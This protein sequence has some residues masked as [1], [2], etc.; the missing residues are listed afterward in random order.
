MKLKTLLFSLFLIGLATSASAQYYFQYDYNFNR[1]IIEHVN[2]NADQIKSGNISSLTVTEKEYRKNGH[3]NNA[4]VY[5]KYFYNQQGQIIREEF[6]N[7]F[8]NL[9]YATNYSIN[10]KGQ[11][12]KKEV[13]HRKR[14]QASSTWV[15]A[16]HNDSLLSELV[17]YN[18]KGEAAWAYRFI[19]NE[20][21]QIQEQRQYHN[22]KIKG[23]IEYD[24]YAD[25]GKKEVR[26][27]DDSLKLEKT[28]R[29]D[30]G[31]G[32]SLLSEKQKDTVTRCSHK[33]E[34]ADGTMRTVEETRDEKGR[35]V[36]TIYDYN[37][38]QKWSETRHYDAK[39]RLRSS[40]RWETMEGGQ[41]KSIYSFYRKGKFKYQTVHVQEKDLFGF[42]S[43]KTMNKD[44]V[45]S[46]V[47]SSYTFFNEKNK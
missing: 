2:R 41:L 1:I 10:E 26:Y 42:F 35:I 14:K 46:E 16:Y 39:N 29:Y 25:K 40:F 5:Y 17:A 6:Y 22:N 30:C 47:V 37:K 24:Y 36:R 11:V 28:Y 7:A 3:V 12:L 9:R 21:N 15:M 45:E 8:G 38:V 18:K 23:R 13:F 31:I 27:F 44:R 19:Y 43:Y 20:Q 33:E 32:N 34:L 4:R